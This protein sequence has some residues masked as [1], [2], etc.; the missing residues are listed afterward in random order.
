M[1]KKEKA[2]KRVVLD[3]NI[4]ISALLFRGEIS[5]I[6]CLWKEGKIIPL[7]SKETF[8]EFR[9]VLEYPK[10][11]LTD[12]EIKTIIEEESLPFFEIVDD[13]GKI[14]GAC[15]DPDD[16]KFISCAVSAGA[17]FI[18]SGDKELCSLGRYK[19]VRIVTA[20]YFLKLYE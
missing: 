2:V 20:S 11:S 10:F 7:V 8:A 14:R 1:G 15:S 12:A 9:Q 18:V 16:D 13:T 17:D 3:T 6:V 5:G 4:L 19:T